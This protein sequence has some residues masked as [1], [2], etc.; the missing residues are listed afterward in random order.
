MKIA[1]RAQMNDGRLDICLIHEISRLK[2]LSVFPSVYFG[3]HLGIREVDYFQ[4]EKARVE[5]DRPLD[6]Y[7]DGEYVCRTPIEI[8]VAPGALRA[9]VS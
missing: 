3:K 1:P 5:A 7:A 9:I 4:A 6:V 2:L 8:G